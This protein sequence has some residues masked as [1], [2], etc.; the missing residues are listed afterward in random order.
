MRDGSLLYIEEI[1]RIPEETLNVLITVMSE[2]ELHVPRLGRVVAEPG[3]R[4]VAAMNPFD[5]IGTARISSAVY[6]RV[7]R[8]VGRLPVGRRRGSDRRQARR[9]RH[10]IPSGWP[11]WSRSYGSPA[12]TPTCASARRCVARSTSPPW[13]PRSHR[14]VARR[15]PPSTSGS[16]ARSSRLSGRL[17]LREGCRATRNRS[18]PSCG[19]RCSQSG[20]SDRS[21]KATAPTGA[22]RRIP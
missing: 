21:G 22:S 7:C 8:L 17:R 6:D 11:R 12:L 3:F 14:C 16:T 2:R 18:S 19:T 9:A 10:R 1:N 15:Q 13:P 4:L 20:E 5:A